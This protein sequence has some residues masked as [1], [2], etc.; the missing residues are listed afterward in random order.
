MSETAAEISRERTCGAAPEI[1][2][3]LISAAVSFILLVFS[4]LYF[5]RVEATM[6]D[7]A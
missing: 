6:A 1:K 4:Y 7:F 5:K 3:L 2:S